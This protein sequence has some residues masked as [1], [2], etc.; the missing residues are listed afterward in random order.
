MSDSE[1]LALALE[2]LRELL[3][4]GDHEGQCEN[5]L[6]S[7]HEGKCTD[8]CFADDEGGCALHWN[9]AKAR[10]KNARAVLAIIESDGGQTA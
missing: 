8:N 3:K 5:C 2:A 4:A 7:F 9:A 1:K 6:E 10:A